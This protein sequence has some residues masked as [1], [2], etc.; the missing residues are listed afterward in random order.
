[1]GTLLKKCFE[2]Q[3]DGVFDNLED[4]LNYFEKL[5]LLK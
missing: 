2:A 4:G 1:M 5:I 3:L